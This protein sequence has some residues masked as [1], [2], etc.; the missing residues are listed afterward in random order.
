MHAVLIEPWPQGYKTFYANS[1][2]Y[3]SRS[4]VGSK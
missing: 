1:T 3:G 2:E 4:A